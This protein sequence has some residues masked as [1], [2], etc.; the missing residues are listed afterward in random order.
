MF[1]TIRS[2]A[3]AVG[4]SAQTLRE[5]ERAGLLRPER[6][7]AGRR[8]FTPIDIEQARRVAADRSKR[9]GFKPARQGA[10]L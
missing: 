4:V 2:A 9:Q 5:Y 6:D 3:K 1:M 7:S 8:V 10:E